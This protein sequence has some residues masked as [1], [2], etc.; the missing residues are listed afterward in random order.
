MWNQWNQFNMEYNFR[1][2]HIDHVTIGSVFD[3]I[4]SKDK[5][6]YMSAIINK[7]D[8]FVSNDTNEE[9]VVTDIK[10]DSYSGKKMYVLVF[11]DTKDEGGF[12]SHVVKKCVLDY[13][14]LFS[15]YHKAE[16]PSRNTVTKEMI[17]DII[18]CSDVVV[19]TVFDKTTVVYMRLPNGFVIVESSSC[20]DPANYDEEIGI[21]ICMDKI[22]D[23]IWEL[24]GYR[25]QCE[26]A[27]DAFDDYDFDC[28]DDKD[29]C[30]K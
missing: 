29:W 12:Q 17:D 16:E 11:D 24:E 21:D 8:K 20:V 22:E 4:I 15:H 23:K 5:E 28:C 10:F 1:P 13:N 9:F 25:L 14:G 19:D 27:N 18:A 6:S 3:G 7:G 2:K 26:L 30:C